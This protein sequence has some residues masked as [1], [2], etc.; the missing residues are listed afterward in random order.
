MLALSSSSETSFG[1]TCRFSN[2]SCAKLRGAANE[3]NPRTASETMN[4]GMLYELLDAI[5]ARCAERG[6][7]ELD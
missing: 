2:A 4:R 3:K 1:S 6:A 7:D 5:V